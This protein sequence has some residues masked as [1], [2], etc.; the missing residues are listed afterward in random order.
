M[1]S[2]DEESD[3][4]DL[5][6]PISDED[7]EKEQSVVLLTVK[8]K[9]ELAK[10]KLEEDRKEKKN[11]AHPSLSTRKDDVTSI[12][13]GVVRNERKEKERI[14]VNGGRKN[15]VEIFEEEELF[16][17]TDIISKTVEMDTLIDE[18]PQMGRIYD[19][20]GL[21]P[22]LSR[23]G[24]G[25]RKWATQTSENVRRSVD[26]LE[27]EIFE[28]EEENEDVENDELDNQTQYWALKE[29]TW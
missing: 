25:E 12:P 2:S 24:D 3:L 18:I 21:I 28:Y 1:S 26:V 20:S 5:P 4:P 17:E 27:K 6:E 23:Q 7:E 10:L 15:T 8:Q 9:Y 14:A 29:M 22:I 19:T 13:K 11:P 16:D